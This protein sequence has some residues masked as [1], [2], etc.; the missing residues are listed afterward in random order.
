MN[1][2]IAQQLQDKANKEHHA[3]MATALMD[4]EM[5]RQWHE[6]GKKLAEEARGK[7]LPFVILSSPS[8]KKRNPPPS[9]LFPVFADP[10][11]GFVP[12]IPLFQATT[13]RGQA[14]KIRVA[15]VGQMESNAT[16]KQVQ[17]R[18]EYEQDKAQVDAILAAVQKDEL[19]AANTRRAQQDATR[20]EIKAWNEERLRLLEEKTAKERASEERVQKYQRDM[21]AREAGKEAAKEAKRE[22][23]DAIY[24]EILRKQAEKERKRLE[25]EM[26]RET[27][28]DEE[29]KL[30]LFNKDQR[31]KAAKAKMI[32]DMKSQNTIIIATRRAQA[33][34]IK[35]DEAL[36]DQRM[37]DKFVE[38]DQKERAKI[39]KRLAADKAHMLSIRSEQAR[40]QE[41]YVE[42]KERELDEIKVAKENREFERKVVE[43]ARR[44][45]LQQHAQTLVDFMPK[46]IV[47]NSEDLALIRDAAAARRR[48]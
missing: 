12:P 6:K 34:A 10:L 42:A 29:E 28:M 4:E 8:Q 20:A 24:A 14:G 2:E 1:K 30:K 39:A 41:L 43:A 31:E 36:Q 47:R 46:G 16:R 33:Q 9:L 5:N 44:R 13:R 45:L 48:Q 7:I 26:L 21:D 15:L 38:D 3:A 23:E 18:A 40:R 27:L 19:A 37:I 32:A 11:C 35:D 25:L 17:G 22:R